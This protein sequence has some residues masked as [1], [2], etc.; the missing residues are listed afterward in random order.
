VPVA[1]VSVEDGSTLY[2]PFRPSS[3]AVS[4]LRLRRTQV[5]AGAY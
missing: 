4:L 2:D 3:Q 1:A 5:L